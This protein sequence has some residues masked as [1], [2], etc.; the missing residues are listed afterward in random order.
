[1]LQHGASQPVGDVQSVMSHA[2]GEAEA[3][4]QVAQSC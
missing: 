1:M 3:A 2:E 4:D